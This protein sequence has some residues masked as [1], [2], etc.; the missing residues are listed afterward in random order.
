MKY[1]VVFS[2]LILLSITQWSNSNP[3]RA[4]S[5]AS[6]DVEWIDASGNFVKQYSVVSQVSEAA[7][8]INDVDL[9]VTQV[10]KSI[11]SV[12]SGNAVV[13]A[14]S[15]INLATGTD[16]GS[17]IPSVIFQLGNSNYATTNGDSTEVNGVIDRGSLYFMLGTA[18]HA[19]THA[20]RYKGTVRISSVAPITPSQSLVAHYTFK[21]ADTYGTASH[22]AKVTSTSDSKGEWVS[23]TE[24]DDEGSNQPAVDSGIFRGVINV[25]V[26]SKH[27]EAGDGVVWVQD[28][29]SLTVTY[30]NAVDSRGNDGIAIASSSAVINSDVSLPDITIMSPADGTI[31]H[32]IRPTFKFSI[33]DDESGFSSQ[34]GDFGKHVALTINGCSVGDAELALSSHSSRA[35]T[36]S[37]TPTIGTILSDIARDSGDNPISDCSATGANVRAYG[38]FNV[39]STSG[40]SAHGTDRTIHGTEFS[41]SVTATNL[42]GFSKS[43]RD[44]DMNITIDSVPPSVSLIT[45]AKAWSAVEK[46]DTRDNS[47]IKIHFNESLESAS[48]SVND[49]VVGGSGVTNPTISAV[50]VA[51]AGASKNMYVYIDL[52]DDLAPNARPKVVLKGSVSDIAGNEL[53]P[54]TSEVNSG[55]KGKL[56]GTA[57]DGIPPTI[58]LLSVTERLLNNDGQTD[59]SFRSN[60]NLTNTS[61]AVGFCTCVSLSGPFGNM[62]T[63]NISVELEDPTTGKFS[64][65]EKENTTDGVYGVTIIAMDTAGNKSVIGHSWREHENVTDNAINSLGQLIYDQGTTSGSQ[66]TF[67]LQKW[68]LADHDGDGSIDDSVTALHNGKTIYM[69]VVS[70]GA[71]VDEKITAVAYS[72]ASFS[73]TYHLDAGTLLVNYYHSS[74]DYRIEVDKAAPGQ[75]EYTPTTGS[76]IYDTTPSVSVVYTDD[77]FPGDSNTTVSIVK[78]ELE[79]PDGTEQ[80]VL[81][82]LTTTD[83]KSFYY[84]P[85]SELSVGRY[86]F[87]TMAEDKLGNRSSETYSI[88]EVREKQKHTISMAS[89]WNLISFPGNPSDGRLGAIFT[90]PLVTVVGTYD[91]T[92]PGGWLVAVR[93][94]NGEFLGNLGSINSYYGYWVFQSN[95]EPISVDIPGVI[96]GVSQV[97]PAISLVQGWNLIPVISLG[98]GSSPEARDYLVGL[99]WVRLKG[100]DA[101][102]KD[103]TDISP[104]DSS[105]KLLLNKGYWL[106]LNKAGTLVP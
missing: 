12:S 71:G 3:V 66:V 29:D 87:K 105:S 52:V 37:Y 14:H 97:P 86:V 11:W 104:T 8:Y 23:I 45:A 44:T 5:V 21:A 59:F 15:I 24:V 77:E 20:D 81:N 22:R 100:W 48:V 92:V 26:D 101:Q 85:T 27:I 89:G 83:N 74:D 28:G 67:K 33:S 56:L 65:N 103:W 62:S 73:S 34:I 99:D 16:D 43:I 80:N 68:P 53:K 96:G 4:Y 58:S 76:V 42:A 10:G 1:V 25:G 35:M 95:D 2:A 38:G 40:P 88:F 78:A 7:F 94:A 9:G 36:F 82:E 17:D 72:D 54:T 60:E 6:D 46:Q 55:N 63:K 51:G 75:P 50:T 69:K 57:S 84:R 98:G 18:D 91:P 102:G 32:D 39:N 61:G 49:F 79:G 31:T 30:Y 106:F 93:Q 90:N 13:S 70:A 47:S 41:W 64:F 19:Y